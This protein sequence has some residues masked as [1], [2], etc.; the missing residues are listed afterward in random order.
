[1]FTLKVMR[2]VDMCWCSRAAIGLMNVNC[3]VFDPMVK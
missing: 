3:S 1:M 2:V